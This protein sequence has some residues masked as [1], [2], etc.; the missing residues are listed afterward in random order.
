MRTRI[1]QTV[2]VC[3]AVSAASFAADVSL[4]IVHG[5]PGRNLAD[6]IMP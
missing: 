4:Y 3:L 2:V 1:L 5:I 6:E